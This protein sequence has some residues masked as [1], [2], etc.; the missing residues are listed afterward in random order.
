LQRNCNHGAP[1]ARNAHATSSGARPIAA[2]RSAS[3][4]A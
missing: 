3:T 4:I 2:Q 1:A